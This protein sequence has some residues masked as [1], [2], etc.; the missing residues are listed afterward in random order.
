MGMSWRK[1][2]AVCGGVGVLVAAGMAWAMTVQPVAVDLTMAG[3]NTSA[4]VRVENNSPTP[5]PVEIR[6]VETDFGP[7]GVSASDR[8]TDEVIAFP[9]QAIIPPGGT[10]VFRLQYV[11]DPGADRSRHF[12]A[13]V[14][15]L[16]VE[17]PEGQSAI[18]ILYNFQVMVNVASM[19]AGEPQLSVTSAEITK[20][21]E[22]E[23]V[24]AFTVANASKNY[25]YLSTGGLTVRH[26]G[27]DGKELSRK[28]MVANEIQQQ[29]GF[30]LVGP[31]T[32]RRFVTPIKLDSA[33]GT[34]EVTLTRSR[35]R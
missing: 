13:E 33:E 31:E 17:L 24:A 28:S 9:P 29:I 7:D 18:Q 5:L 26:I 1:I 8:P 10:Q 23:P 27:P 2:A 21:P 30:G 35:G 11:G 3:R 14:A 22:G 25:G 32:S 12:Y 16:P 20:N 15:Q 34:L 4:P 6:L 19:I